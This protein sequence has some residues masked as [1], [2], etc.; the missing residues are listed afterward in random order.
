MAQ[1]CF[2]VPDEIYPD[3]VDALAD[4]GGY[5]DEETNGPKDPFA[6]SIWLDF[7]NTVHKHYMAGKAAKAAAEDA[8]DQVAGGPSI[9]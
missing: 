8:Y 7:A 2:D 5:V 6:R 3:V 9:S 1:V 4:R